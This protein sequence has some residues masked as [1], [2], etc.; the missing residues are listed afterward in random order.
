MKKKVLLSTVMMTIVF[1]LSS[2]SCFAQSIGQTF[3]VSQ[4]AKV[5]RTNGTTEYVDM[6]FKV[7]GVDPAT[8]EIYYRSYSSISNFGT[9]KTLEIPQYV[10]YNNQGYW[11][12]SVG[13][14]GSS[15]TTSITDA[16]IDLQ[17]IVEIISKDA[18][19]HYNHVKEIAGTDALIKIERFGFGDNR[20]LQIIDLSKV[21]EIGD[22]AFINCDSLHSVD[23]T[24]I[25]KLGK[26]AFLIGQNSTKYGLT[27]L[28]LGEQLESIPYRCFRNNRGLKS[29]RIP[30]NSKIIG[31]QAFMN[32]EAL[33]NLVIDPGVEEIGIRAFAGCKLRSV[34]IP[35]GVTAIGEHAFSTGSVQNRLFEIP[36]SITTIGED[37]FYNDNDSS[38]DTLYV[39]ATTPPVCTN[40]LGNKLVV[41]VP[42]GCRA[43]Y[44]T[45]DVWKD[46]YNIVEFSPTITF[47]DAKVKAL[48]L[49]NWDT[50]GDGKFT[51][52]EATAVTDLGEVFKEN[53][54]ITSFNELQYFTSLSSITSNTFYGCRGLAS[55]TIPSNVTSIENGAF[56]YCDVLTSIIVDS[57]N[58]TYDSRNGCNAIIETATNT[59][60]AG[61]KS[62]IIPNNVTS[63]SYHAFYGCTGLTSITIPNSVTSIGYY[64]F[65]FCI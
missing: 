33:E 53:T 26:A 46:V 39:H 1:M 15:Q 41:F 2:V 28:V 20:R 42:K 57:G 34:K 47:A 48:C 45:A 11:V 37:A 23:L 36:S 6:N 43:A 12:T 52:E 32:C 19:G 51:E 50:D 35:E 29:V 60:I 18:F 64:V 44:L 25:R 27:D 58:A 56:R 21:E 22:S 63:I 38:V 14:M 31:E 3:T 8:V 5:V 30:G 16:K 55:I 7:T 65:S 62:T 54:E 9:F 17:E 10:I 49:A 24:N 61:C 13:F 59:L 40:S 4:C